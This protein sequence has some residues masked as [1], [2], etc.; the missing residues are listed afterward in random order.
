MACLVAAGALGAD[1]MLGSLH[2]VQDSLKSKVHAVCSMS[3]KHDL[4]LPLPTG[5]HLLMWN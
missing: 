4:L 5:I 2:G 1:D 3:W